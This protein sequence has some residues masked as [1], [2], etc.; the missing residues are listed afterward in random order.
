MIRLI[1]RWL[2]L[3]KKKPTHNEIKD[4]IFKNIGELQ[5]VRRKAHK[6]VLA[7]IKPKENKAIMQECDHHLAK[8]RRV[9]Q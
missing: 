3:D 7:N 1:R 9:I 6:N 2:R 8:L 5:E 4:A